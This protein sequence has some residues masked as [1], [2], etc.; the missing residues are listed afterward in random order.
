MYEID[1]LMFREI[2]IQRERFSPDKVDLLMADY[3]AVDDRFGDAI[4]QWLEDRTIAEIS[5]H[6]ISLREVLEN[7]Q[8]HFLVAI[9]SL[10]ELL[11]TTFR[12]PE[13]SR[14]IEALRT[15]VVFE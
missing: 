13:R 14:Q 4:E 5:V 15:P 7:K 1:K 2:L 6:G 10:N 11:D 8:V 9:R 12:E 3:P